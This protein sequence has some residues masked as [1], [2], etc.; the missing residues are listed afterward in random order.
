MPYNVQ[1]FQKMT[2]G[3]CEKISYN[4]YLYKTNDAKK[5]KNIG[6]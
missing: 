2:C 3:L 4:R 5:Q 1:Q 6:R